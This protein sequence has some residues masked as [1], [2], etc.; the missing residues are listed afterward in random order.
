MDIL[1]KP[2]ISELQAGCKVA[3]FWQVEGNVSC[4]HIWIVVLEVFVISSN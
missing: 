1:F 3:N 2:L 4:Q